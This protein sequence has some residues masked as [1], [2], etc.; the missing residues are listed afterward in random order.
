[1]K[2]NLK[3]GNTVD[4]GT[5][6]YLRHGG[7]K[8]NNNFDEIYG[9]LGDGSVPFSSGAW[10][11]WKTSDGT[12]LNLKFGQSYVIETSN[13]RVQVQLPKGTPSDYNKT[14]KLRDVFSTWQKNPVT[15]APGSGDTMKGSASGVVFAKNFQ[16]LELVYCSPGRWEYLENKFVDKIS[17]SNLSTVTSKSYIATQGQTDFLDVFEGNLFNIGNTNVYRRGNRLYYSVS[18][19]GA[20]NGDSDFGSPAADGTITV[21]DGKN[22][23]LKVP[24]VEGETI[25]IETF[26]DGVSTW[27]SSYNRVSIKLRDSKFTDAKSIGGERFV[28]DLKNKK[29]FTLDDLGLILGTKINPYSVEILL[30]GRQLVE[31]GDASLPSFMCDGAFGETNSECSQNGGI[32][33]ESNSDYSV[34]IT[35]DTVQSIKFSEGFEDGDILIFRWFNNNIGT[36]MD[37][38]DI[39]TVTDKRYINSQQPVN[40]INRIEYTDYNNPKQANMRPVADQYAI[41]ISNLGMLFDIFHPI[42]TIY[43]NAHN[44]ANPSDYMGFG[45]WTLYGQ[46]KAM[47]GWNSNESDPNFALN[48]N[49]LDTSGNPSHTA[50]G[51]VGS[52][53]VKLA[54]NNIPAMKSKDKVLVVDDKG[55][56]IVGGCQFDPDS[57]GPGYSKY[58]EDTLTV[59]DD[60]TEA[61]EFSVIQPSITSYRWLRVA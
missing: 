24:C 31:S 2:Q 20:L 17:N 15:V 47:V 13:G 28:G 49:D 59:N 23:R 36:T 41:N 5:G 44:P 30:N 34:V 8:I 22:I 33:V 38:D 26:L 16:D 55:P 1:M 7:L 56:I 10:K 39:T 54:L 46:G 27:Q 57:E 40:L 6:D 12:V 35:D 3:V 45:T 9:E 52:T 43:E 51:T 60:I 18:Q 58:R 14:V 53:K 11:T 19:S 61:V 21:L 50:G 48:N 25:I 4:D 32:W 37:I 42:G 29:E